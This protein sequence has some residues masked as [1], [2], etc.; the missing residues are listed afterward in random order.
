[1]ASHISASDPVEARDR[2]LICSNRRIRYSSVFGWMCSARAA[3]PSPD[4]HQAAALGSTAAF[5]LMRAPTASVS[6]ARAP[7]YSGRA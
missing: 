1:M 3:G 2:P 7:E 5:W 6:P 4:S